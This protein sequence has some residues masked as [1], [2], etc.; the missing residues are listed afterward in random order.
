MVFV[1]PVLSSTNG[2]FCPTSTLLFNGYSPSQ[3]VYFIQHIVFSSPLFISFDRSPFSPNI[4][5]LNY[6]LF[7][8]YRSIRSPLLNCLRSLMFVSSRTT[9][10]YNYLLTLFLPRSF[11]QGCCPSLVSPLNRLTAGNVTAQQQDKI[12]LACFLPARGY[13]NDAPDA[14]V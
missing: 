6:P 7:V 8:R 10:Y 5:Q 9:I 13:I 3:L 2:V 11:S 12:Q 14:S 4:L 1:Q